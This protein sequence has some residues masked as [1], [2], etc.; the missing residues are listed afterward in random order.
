M[1]STKTKENKSE[2]T[3]SKSTHS[4]VPTVGRRSRSPISEDESHQSGSALSLSEPETESPSRS[5]NSRSLSTKSR[6]QNKV[7]IE[8]EE[9]LLKESELLNDI[10][11]LEKLEWERDNNIYNY[12][13]PNLTDPMF[14]KKITEKIEFDNTKY[15]GSIAYDIEENAE[16]KCNQEFELA[17]HQ[18]FVR[19]FLS[20]QTPYNSL[21]LYHGLGTGKTCSAIGVAEEMRNYTKQIGSTKRIIVIASPNVQDNFKLQLFD[22]SKLKFTNGEWNIRSCVGEKLIQEINPLNDPNIT[23]EKIV[24]QIK[25]LISLSYFFMGY[26]EFANYIAKH[27][28]ISDSI[29]K[30]Q[31]LIIERKLKKVFENRMIIIDEIHNV[32][33][34]DDNK[35][36]RVAEELYILISYVKSLKLLLLSATPMY[37]TY[38][39]IIWLINIMNLND[40]RS[41]I[42][43]K[44]VFDSYG[45]F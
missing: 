36:K 1:S 8:L 20:F 29:K 45:T 42:T 41:Q 11:L 31:K 43:E 17:N 37:N 28:K 44:E 13:Y 18:L 23:K 21:L 38:K 19:N 39:E 4:D 24:S 33:T 5:R 7:L 26:I 32:R 25:R 3:S 40:N 34:T 12:L 16:L 30:N 2:R 6:K 35:E 27:R 22:E 9:E 10:E 15:D 14:N